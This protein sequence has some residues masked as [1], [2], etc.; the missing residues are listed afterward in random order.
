MRRNLSE[1]PVPPGDRTFVYGDVNARFAP[2]AV[3]TDDWLTF[4]SDIPPLG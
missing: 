4:A 3:S 2:E 1:A